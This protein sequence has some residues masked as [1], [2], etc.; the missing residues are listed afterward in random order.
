MVGIDHS[1]RKHK[2]VKVIGIGVVKSLVNLYLV[3]PILELPALDLAALE[4]N[5]NVL[6]P[7]SSK[8]LRGS[9]S[10]ACSNPSVAK[11]AIFF[12]FSFEAIPFPP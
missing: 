2:S 7:A 10:S 12:P 4:R 8:A 5:N 1:A 11:I 9:I 6:A 3:A